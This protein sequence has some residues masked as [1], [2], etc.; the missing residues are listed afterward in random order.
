MQQGANGDLRTG[1]PSQMVDMHVPLRCF[2]VVDAPPRRVKIVLKRHPDLEEMLFNNWVRLATRDPNTGLVSRYMKGIF[3]PFP[4]QEVTDRKHLT[5]QSEWKTYKPTRDRGLMIRRRE[6]NVSLAASFLMILSFLIPF[7]LLDTS[8]MMNAHGTAIAACATTISLPVLAFSRRYMHGENLFVRTALLSSMLVLGFNFIAM[9]P[10]LDDL[11]EG[12]AL[13]GL[14]STF[15]IGTYNDRVTVQSNALFALASYRFADM[16]LLIS[17]AFGREDAIQTGCYKPEL[18]AGGLI[19][20]AMFKS[21]QF[22]LTTLFARSMEGPTPSSALGYAGL[23]AHVGLVLLSSTVDSWMPSWPARTAIASVGAITAV[24]AGLVSLIH[25]DRKGAL[26]YATSSTIGLLYCIMAAGYVPEALILALGHSS[27]RIGQILRAPNEL[28]HRN[29][30]G[31][32]LGFTPFQEVVSDRQFELCWSLHR[33]DTDT[34]L[35]Y[36]FY[37][38][39]EP[40]D[41][42]RVTSPTTQTR[43]MLF[44]V[45]GLAAAGFPFTPLSVACDALIVDLLPKAPFLACFLMV[46]VYTMSLIALRFLQLN[47]L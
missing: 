8:A 28:L 36:A 6:M 7:V 1:L 43:K 31:A 29:S 34:N 46:F 30:I 13:F 23:S 37:H 39:I 25:A 5:V 41:F 33:F 17:V 38:F 40:L 14:A 42:L 9:A 11:V 18:V 32:M 20:A 4:L 2:F 10:R 26:A 12:W 24:H 35:I 45:I 3:V 16:A 47:V 21:S 15:L 27:L 44:L 22:P 19:T